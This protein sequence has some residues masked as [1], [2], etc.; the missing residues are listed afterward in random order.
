MGQHGSLPLSGVPDP[1]Y[2]RRI[3]LPAEGTLPQ[4]WL[5]VARTI[6]PITRPNVVAFAAWAGA[7]TRQWVIVSLGVGLCLFWL[8]ALMG[9]FFTPDIGLVTLHGLTR[10]DELLLLLSPVFYL[11]AVL[12]IPL[13]VAVVTPRYFGKLGTRFL[14]VMRPW[15]LAQVGMGVVLVCGQLAKC[16]IVVATDH[17]ELLQGNLLLL[18]RLIA[19]AFVLGLSTIALS[20]GAYRSAWTVQPIGIVIYLLISYGFRWLGDYL[21]QLL[22]IR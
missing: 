9:S 7:A 11:A 3:V 19:L 12:L 8:N 13:A 1:E 6:F 16:I 17:H 14:R 20:V 15:A 5:A 4:A 21:T 18:P 10:K 2:N 22:A